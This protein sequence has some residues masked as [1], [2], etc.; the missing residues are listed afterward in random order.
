MYFAPTTYKYN[1]DNIDWS[2]F[3]EYAV[4]LPLVMGMF[5]SAN[6]TAYSHEDQSIFP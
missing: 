4:L 1:N 3:G 6:K 5:H 2:I